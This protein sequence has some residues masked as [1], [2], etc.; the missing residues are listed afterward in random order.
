M[1][2]LLLHHQQHTRAFNAASSFPTESL[3][4]AR[5]LI[6]LLLETGAAFHEARTALSS[7]TERLRKEPS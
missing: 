4:E 5:N 6:D 3:K 1:S 7:L 2:W